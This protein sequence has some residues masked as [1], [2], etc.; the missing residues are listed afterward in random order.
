MPSAR[1]HPVGILGLQAGEEVKAAPQVP[2]EV[3]VRPSSFQI[4]QAL[5][6]EFHEPQG[7][8]VAFFALP[9]L[10]AGRHV[11]TA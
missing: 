11:R 7:C 2:L 3:L 9:A 1:T 5:A 4:E 8:Q 6:S 10:G